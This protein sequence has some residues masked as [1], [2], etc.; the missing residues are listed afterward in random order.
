MVILF[1]RFDLISFRCLN[2]LILIFSGFYLTYDDILRAHS[3]TRDRMFYGLNKISFFMNFYVSNE[4]S[5]FIT[6]D[7]FE[8]LIDKVYKGLF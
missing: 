3:E 4:E 7:N 5:Y 2:L 6:C 1:D 8:D